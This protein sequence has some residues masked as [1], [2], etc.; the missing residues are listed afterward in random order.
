[1]RWRG[2]CQM[3]KPLRFRHLWSN[4]DEYVWYSYCG[5]KQ[6]SYLILSK[7]YQEP[8]CP[9]CERLLLKEKA[10]KSK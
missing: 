6:S 10:E 5:L 8:K 4:T 9:E 7:S 2:L 3:T 1:M